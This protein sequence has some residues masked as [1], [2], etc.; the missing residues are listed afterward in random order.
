MAKTLWE[1]E[2]QRLRHLF[3]T[4]LTD[5][6]DEISDF[7]ECVILEEEMHHIENN[8]IIRRIRNRNWKKLLSKKQPIICY[9][10]IPITW[11]K[12]E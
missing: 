5:S 11:E 8:L 4:V 10:T 9:R 7:G 2:Q 6:K 12:T 3:D 1:R